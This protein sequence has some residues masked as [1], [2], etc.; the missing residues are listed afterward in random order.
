MTSYGHVLKGFEYPLLNFVI[1]S[2]SDIFGREKKKEKNIKNMRG[3]RSAIL[4]S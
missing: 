1:L 3:R 4:Q 2:E